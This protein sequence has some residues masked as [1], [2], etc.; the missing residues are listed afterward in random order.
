MTHFRQQ[1]AKRILSFLGKFGVAFR[2]MF[3]YKWTA[4]SG[5]PIAFLLSRANASLISSPFTVF[6]SAARRLV[7]AIHTFTWQSQ[8]NASLIHSNHANTFTPFTRIV[9][10]KG[11]TDRGSTK[12][13]NILPLIARSSYPAEV[14]KWKFS[15][16]FSAKGVVKF[17]VKCSVLRF[18]GFGCAREN[19]TKISHQ[20]RCEK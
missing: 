14:W 2:C 4:A 9:A 1:F 12:V 10:T 11:L 5:P 18:P 8:S 20:K 3:Q 7:L 6:F 17:G 16:F 19:F 15:P 13:W